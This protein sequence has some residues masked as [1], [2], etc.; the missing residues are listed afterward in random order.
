MASINGRINSQN[1][2]SISSDEF[3]PT[4]VELFMEGKAMLSLEANAPIHTKFLLNGMTPILFIWPPQW[5]GLNI[6]EYLFYI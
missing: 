2:L 3:H 6:N 5:P 1:Y 4:F